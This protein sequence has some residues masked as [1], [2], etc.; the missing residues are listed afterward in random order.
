[1]LIETTEW[2]TFEFPESYGFGSFNSI[3]IQ[4]LQ[5]F[6]FLN[7]RGKVTFTQTKLP[8]ANGYWNIDG[9]E[10]TIFYKKKPY[11]I[12]HTEDC[13]MGSKKLYDFLFHLGYKTT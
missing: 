13:G 11:A 2:Q 6:L 7:T 10:F 3:K 1:M 9:R 12:V 5:L 8:T 4:L